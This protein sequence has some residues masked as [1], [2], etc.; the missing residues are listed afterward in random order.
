MDF[1]KYQVQAMGFRKDTADNVYAL[2]G[3]CEEAGEV[4]GK[5]AKWRRD[6]TDGEQLRLD[7]AKELGDVL[8]MVSAIATDFNLYLDDIAQMNLAKLQGR[9]DRNVISGKGD[10]R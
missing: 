2:L 1:T 6:G 4:A 7:V 9:K 5:V 8:W 10:E 3:L